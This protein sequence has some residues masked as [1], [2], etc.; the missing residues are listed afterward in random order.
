MEIKN[1]IIEYLI[2]ILGLVGGALIVSSIALLAFRLDYLFDLFIIGIFILV[3]DYIIFEIYLEMK[4][5]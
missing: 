2:I 5:K 4:G 3:A 1:N